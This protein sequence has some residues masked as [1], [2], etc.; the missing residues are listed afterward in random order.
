[1]SDGN[2]NRNLLPYN[3][4]QNGLRAGEARMKQ[5]ALDAF[6]LWC[7]E[8]FGELEDAELN[9]IVLKYKALLDTK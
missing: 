2:Y 8:R 7:R 9:D 1:M 3:N 4:F 5:K 6:K